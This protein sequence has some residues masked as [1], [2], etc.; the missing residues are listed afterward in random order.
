MILCLLSV[1]VV[2]ASCTRDD[3]YQKKEDTPEYVEPATIDL[4]EYRTAHDIPGYKS[5]L[6]SIY[7]LFANRSISDRFYVWYLY[8]DSYDR[9]GKDSLAIVYTDSAIQLLDNNPPSNFSRDNYLW[10]YYFKADK[11]LRRK[12]LDVAYKYY[13]KALSMAEKYHDTCAIGYYDLKIGLIMFSTRQYKDA[14]RYFVSAYDN[15][16]TCERNF[17]YFYRTQELLNDIGLCFERLSQ[18]DSAILYYKRDIELLESNRENFPDQRKSH[19]ELAIAIA[20]GNLGGAYAKAGM[21]DSAEQMFKESLSQEDYILEEPT[22]AQ[23]TRLKL[24]ELYIGSGRLSEAKGL[25]DEIGE[26]NNG[27][28]DRNV[29]LR[30]DKV[31]WQ[32]WDKMGDTKKAY[33]YLQSYRA[34]EDTA[35][36]YDISFSLASLDNNVKNIGNEYKISVLEETASQRKM[37][38][39][40]LI[41]IA[42]FAVVIIF[43][44]INNL[45]R[46]KVHVAKLTEMND[47]INEQRRQLENT[48]QELENATGEKDRI[49]KAVSHDMRSPINSSLALVDILRSQ[50][51]KLDEEQLEYI[52]LIKKSNE[53]A[54]GLTKDLLEVA[55]LNTEQ[56]EKEP[57]DITSVM[58]DRVKLLKYKAAEKGQELRFSA[59]DDHIT[60]T[61]NEEKIL[62]ILSN[63]VTNAI[64]FSSIGGVINI[65]LNKNPDSFILKVQDNGIGIPDKMKGHV[66]DLFSE[67]K[68]FGTSGEQ[69][70][71][72]GLSITK[73][74]VEAH[75]GKIWF[76]SEEGRGT[77][78]YVEIP[79]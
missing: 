11:E 30:L 2:F 48:L 47:R 45:R 42:L 64:K 56:L 40:A 52:D 67:A 43:L 23:F 61:V 28:P 18:Y 34:K 32:Y 75:S 60:A 29:S 62:R 6:D 73:Q 27:Q 5:Y 8:A 44:V 46:S 15:C 74:I 57:V 79:L 77:T 68:R 16:L 38:L 58:R 31:Y 9:I 54:L 3:N 70:F 41:I 25:I 33:S 4:G 35:R 51:D 26:I 37:Y 12:N 13:Y 22:D 71:G 63:L 7:A 66:F 59:P 14:S 36:K 39:V 78:F 20:K 24:A 10:A 76:E 21:P 69:P 50:T 65:D 19:M 55:T 49:L 1:V 72:L 17:G 53:N